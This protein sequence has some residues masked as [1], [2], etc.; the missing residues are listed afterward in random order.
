MSWLYLLSLS[1][2]KDKK[3]KAAK[4]HQKAS[5]KFLF[6]RLLECFTL[7]FGSFRREIEKILIAKH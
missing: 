7:S 4:K 2:G 3:R 6:H 1:L 5:P